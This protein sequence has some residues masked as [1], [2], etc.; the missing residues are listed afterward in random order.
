MCVY[1][2]LY[3]QG[4]EDRINDDSYRYQC[5]MFLSGQSKMVDNQN[6]SQVKGLKENSTLKQY[7]IVILKYL[8][9]L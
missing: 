3:S 2:S 4:K 5:V 9:R 1:D 8:A 6:L 7:F